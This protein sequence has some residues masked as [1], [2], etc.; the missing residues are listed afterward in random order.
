MERG[1][2]RCSVHGCPSLASYEV[3][4]Y[5]FDPVEG[6][7]VFVQDASCPTICVEHAIANERMAQ[8]QRLP[9]H[10]IAY[11]YTNRERVPGVNIYLELEP[12][13]V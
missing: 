10:V 5:D 11:P 8:G 13:L 12:A 2:H 1:T 4:L 6:A 3:M 7:V 9:H